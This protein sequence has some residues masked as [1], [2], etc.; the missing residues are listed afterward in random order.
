MRVRGR[1]NKD[2]MAGR[3]LQGFQK[4]VEGLRSQHVHFVDDINL[5]AAINRRKGQL[6]PQSFDFINAAIG[7]C[8]DFKYIHGGAFGN[9]A[10]IIAHATGIWSRSVL[11][12]QRLSQNASCAGLARAT[13]PGK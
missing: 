11:T 6:V 8:I 7:C 9:A 3:F 1:Q 2:N 4:R 10:T 5:V 13:R 12:V